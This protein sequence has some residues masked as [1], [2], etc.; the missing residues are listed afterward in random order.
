MH[1]A[2]A[3]TFGFMPAALL[4]VLAA[5]AAPASAPVTVKIDNFVFGPAA[6]TVAPGTTVTWVN[7]DDIPHNIVADDKS[8]RSKVLDTDEKFSFTFTKPGE[9]GYFCGL[10]P[11]MTGKVIVKAG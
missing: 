11:H 7:E 2:L 1:L 10:H 8:F 9:Y 4:P 3:L 5:A 6:I